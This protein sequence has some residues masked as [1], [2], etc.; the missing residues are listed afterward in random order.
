[1]YP[2]F[3]GLLMDRFTDGWVVIIVFVFQLPLMDLRYSDFRDLLH[4]VTVC[5]LETLDPRLTQLKK[6]PR[7]WFKK[8]IK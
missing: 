5:P 1:M 8:L 6:Q 4:L 7:K 3:R 2:L